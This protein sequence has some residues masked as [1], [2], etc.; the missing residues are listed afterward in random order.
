MHFPVTAVIV[1]EQEGVAGISFAPCSFGDAE[2][3]EKQCTVG[4]GFQHCTPYV[5]TVGAE[6]VIFVSFLHACRD[7]CGARFVLVSLYRCF[8]VQEGCC[9]AD[10]ACFSDTEEAEVFVAA[11]RAEGEDVP[12]DRREYCGQQDFEPQGFRHEKDAD[13][14]GDEHQRDGRRLALQR[15]GPFFAV[16]AYVGAEIRV[17]HEPSVEPVR[18]FAVEPCGEQ[19]ERGG[20]KQRQKDAQHTEFVE[21]EGGPVRYGTNWQ[22]EIFQTAISQDYNVTVS[23]GDKKGNYMYS[24]GYTDQ[25]GVIVNSYYRRYTARANNSRKINDF[26]ELGTNISFATSDNRLARTNSETYGVIPAA[27]SF[28]PT[29]PVFD[30]NKDSGFSEDFSTGLANPYLTVHTEKN[31]QETLNVFISS[32]G[33]LK[34]TDWLKFRQNFGYGYSYYERNTYNNRWTGAGIAPTNGYATKSDD[35]YESISTE[36]LLTFNKKFGVHGINAVL[37]MTYENSMWHSKWMAAS[38]FP[39]DMTED[40]VIEAGTKD[41]RMESSRGKSQLMSYLF[42]ANYNLLDRYLFTFSMRRDGSSKLS[43]LNRWNNFYSGAVAWRLSDESFVK[44]LNFFDDLKLR[45]SAGQTGGQGVSAYAT[46]SR[47][48]VSNYG[49][50]GSLQSGMAESRWGGPAAALLKWETTNQFD[51]GLDIAFLNNRVNLTV[52]AYYKKT[53]DLLLDKLI[54]MSSGFSRIQANYGNVTNKGL[55]ISGHFIPVKARNFLWSIDANISFNRNKVGGLDA[56]QYSDVA[57]GIEN[58]FLVRNGEPI[59]TLYGYVEDG[60]YDNEAEVRADPLY[61]NETDS[62]VKSMVGEVK[63]KNLD[64]DPVIDNRDRQIIGNTNPDYQYGITNTLEWKNWTFSFFLQGTQGNDVLNVN[65]KKFDMASVDNMPYFIY[66]NRWTAENRANAKWPRANRTS[67]RSMK[68][69]DRYIEDGSYLRCKN[70]SLSYRFRHPMK[71]VESINLVASV[72]NLFTISGYSWMDPDVNSFG[73]DPKR[74]G[75]DMASYPSAR[76]FNFGVQIGF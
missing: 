63:Y 35:A 25:Q 15:D 50:G 12:R 71:F 53:K 62:K 20:G 58:M 17:A 74:R 56:D 19:Q 59:G 22:D 66:N 64:D 43:E 8:A 10:F 16:V 60:F 44:Q 38:N 52:D 76:T 72:S 6:Q 65:L 1:D 51:I 14:N 34:F 27:I 67:T 70:V 9:T 61:R 31:I 57:W 28:N 39:N 45:V 37:G 69:S 21:K 26:L 7:G 75:V 40:N 47:F 4:A 46:R 42:R 23:G 36:S 30:P 32:F 11:H 54:P 13:E 3:V 68:A 48:V 55:E 5:G 41:R 29:R 33:E 24:G 73:S 18:P 49:M 2:A